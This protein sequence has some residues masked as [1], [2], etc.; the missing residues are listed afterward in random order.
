MYLFAARFTKFGLFCAILL[1]TACT[2]DS[3]P[4]TIAAPAP[5]KSTANAS[6]VYVIA[7]DYYEIKMGIKG[8]EITGVYRH[9][10]A[11]NDACLFFFEG[12]IGAGNPVQVKCYNPTNNNPPFD[13]SFKILG[14]AMIARLDK[15]LGEQCEPEFLDAV[16]HSLVLDER[17]N[18]TAIRMVKE[19]TPLY[20]DAG[21]GLTTG[22]SLKKGAVVGV[23]EQRDFWL[24][25]D[26]QDGDREQGWIPEYVLYPLLKE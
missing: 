2:A 17:V 21:E 16:G 10:T 14:D 3:P 20:E 15:S 9:P 11:E 24:F 25:V 8:D 19:P 5:S 22:K 26:V 23:R 4:E 12:R 6:N 13:G 18:W 7:G 1:L